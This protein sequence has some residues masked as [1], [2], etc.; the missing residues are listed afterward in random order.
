MDEL[1]AH[2]RW[3]DLAL[4]IVAAQEAY[5]GQDAPTLSDAE[6]DS[7]M[8]ELMTLEDT[9][10]EL[11]TPDSPTQHVGRPS[12]RTDFAPVT[13]LERLLSLDNVFSAEELRA[14]MQRTQRL[15]DRQPKWLCELKIDGLA[16]DLVYRDGRL[17][18]AATRGDGRVGED[19][20]GNVLTIGDIPARLR[21]TD[22]PPLVEVRG[23]VFFPVAAF[24]QLNAELVA[25]GKAPFA[26]PRNAAAGS[27]RQKDPRVTAARPL[28]MLVHG[29]GAYEGFQLENQSEAYELLR[30]W[31]LPTSTHYQVVRGQ[32]E[33]DEYV[34]WVGEHR[35][36]PVIEHEL[37]GVVVKVD[38][39]A[40]HALLGDTSRA[41]KWAIAYKFPPEEV[42]TKLLDIQVGVGRTGR[43]TPFGVMAPVRV[44]G[45]TVE[46]ATLHNGFE[47]KRKGVLIGDTVVLRKAGD[48]IPEIVG[49]VVALRDG[50]QREFVMPTH[51]PS[52]GAELR[53]EKEDDKDIRCPNAQHCPAQLRER[54]FALASRSA[55]D[56]EALGLEAAIAL[57]DPDADRPTD[58]QEPRQVSVLSSEASLF[59]LTVADLAGVKVWRRGALEPYFFTKGTANKPSVPKE[60][61]LQLFRELEAARTRPL[62]RVLV[63]LSI[64][65]VGPTAARSLAD[66]FGSIDAIRAADAAQLASVDGVGQV[67]ADAVQEWFSVDWHQQTIAAWAAAG[68]RMADEAK[69][70][71]V[72]VLA[73]LTIV[74]TGTLNGFSR[75]AAK[76]AIISRG[77]KAASS[78]SAKTSY[79]VVGDNPG[80]KADDAARLGVTILNEEQFVALLETGPVEQAP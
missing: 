76:E 70:E 65:H 53:P 40:D 35:H 78:V 38:A 41:P 36:D 44:A 73:G 45:S 27:L 63:A 24:E 54:V 20:T 61:T 42:N 72:P 58:T 17:V 62:W 43:I 4:A 19:I 21:G 1:N 79:V 8:R 55:L 67:I 59:N 47:V 71:G 13:H 74:V 26:N 33:V 18:S 9:Y 66:A 32:Q 80:S 49:P 56:I 7:M 29:L 30:G 46:R 34:R 48:V 3:S 23:E 16:V 25:A 15:L 60:T 28:S 6:Y 10:P 11:R 5:Y 2:Q 39:L 37:D 50:T 77:G 31:G 12:E 52:C 22:V 75:D 51:C 57:S 69:P 68:V 64:R 14:W